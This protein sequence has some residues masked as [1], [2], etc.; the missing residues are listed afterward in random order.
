MITLWLLA[1]S[2]SKLPAPCTLG[3]LL[4][5]VRRLGELCFLENC[6]LVCVPRSMCLD[7]KPQ[8]K[9][10]N[11]FHGIEA[12]MIISILLHHYPF[13]SKGRLAGKQKSKEKT[14]E[15]VCI[16]LN[17]LWKPS[18][19]ANMSTGVCVAVLCLYCI[20]QMYPCSKLYPKLP[21]SCLCLQWA[22]RKHSLYYSYRIL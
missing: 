21:G 8:S 16:F 9:Y 4:D 13:P 15:H 7:S 10:S 6:F 1:G 11:K 19:S 20:D 14:V 2:H 22:F 12:G 5:N 17:T 18:P 3:K